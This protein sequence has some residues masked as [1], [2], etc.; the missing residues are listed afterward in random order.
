MKRELKLAGIALPPA[1][2]AGWKRARAVSNRQAVVSS[3]ACPELCVMTQAVGTPV[4]PISSRNANV[5][6]CPWR[7]AIRG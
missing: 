3:I 7:K 5:P 6:C 4:T 2:R 1:S